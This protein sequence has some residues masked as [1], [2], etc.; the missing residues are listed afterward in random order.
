M[1]EYRYMTVWELLNFLKIRV[2]HNVE[3]I[4]N[5]VQEL[6]SI[7]DRFGLNTENLARI[8]TITQENGNLSIENNKLLSVFNEILKLHNSYFSDISKEKA[9]VSNQ[10]KGNFKSEEEYI[11]YF[12][13]KT[14]NGEIPLNNEHPLK[15]DKKFL[16]K[17][18]ASC[19]KQEQYE[20]CA[21]IK[22]LK[23]YGQ[24]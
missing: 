22:H 17:M 24:L 7:K 8:K 23:E 4:N 20:K 15:S 6:N 10:N 18:F 13:E 2:K 21:T 3:I 16:D 9:L 12:I 11:N 14:I 5:N 19:L 1:E